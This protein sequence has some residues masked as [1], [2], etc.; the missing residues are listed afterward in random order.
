MDQNAILGLDETRERFFNNRKLSPH[1]L[2]YKFLVMML[3]VMMF[4]AVLSAIPAHAQSTPANSDAVKLLQ[5][6]IQNFQGADH[7]WCDNYYTSNV[8][9]SSA[10]SKSALA[11]SYYRYGGV[12]SI[13]VNENTKVT[14]SGLRSSDPDQDSL[15]YAWSQVSGDPISFSPSASAGVISFKAPPVPPHEVRTVVLSLTV[16]DG[17]S[18]KDTTTFNVIVL[19]VNHPPVVK[20]GP[21]QVVDEGTQVTLT[22]SATDADNDPITYT[23]GQYSGPEVELSSTSDTTTSFVSPSITPGSTKPMLFILTADDG[24][25][26]RASALVKVTVKSSHVTPTVTCSDISVNENTLVRLSAAVSNPSNDDLSFYWRQISGQPV[27]LTG[28]DSLNPTFMAPTIASPS[29]S[30]RFQLDVSDPII[31]IPSCQVDVR[32]N[33]VQATGQAP[34]ADAGPDQDVMQQTL[35]TLDGSASTG[36]NIVYSWTQSGGDP[37]TLLFKNTVHPAFFAPSVPIGE[38]KTYEFKLTVSNAFGQSSDTVQI[39]VHH[40][41]NAP[42]A[43]IIPVP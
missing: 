13:V 32:I 9:Q 11:S 28:A 15:T 33:Q 14:L 37:V 27:K 4:A 3:A 35:V 39:T 23:W 40:D 16:D 24:H 1:R 17:H 12:N 25:G 31:D 2:D 43:R 22:G 10:V 30:L 20:V 38:S 36:D 34:V 21:D 29:A 7:I 8:Y 19:H 42:T 26:G 6:C 41:N 5:D 18:A